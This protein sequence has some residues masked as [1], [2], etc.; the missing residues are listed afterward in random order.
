M[1]PPQSGNRHQFRGSRSLNL[2]GGQENGV[3]PDPENVQFFDLEVNNVSN[4]KQTGV[5]AHY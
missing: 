1:E 2:L 3:P 4:T 5:Q